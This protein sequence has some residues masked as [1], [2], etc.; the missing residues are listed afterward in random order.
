MKLRLSHQEI[1][2]TGLGIAGRPD[3]VQE[4]R[5]WLSMFLDRFY[6][7]Q[8]VE[9]LVKPSGDLALVEG[10]SLPEDYRAMKSAT[11]RQSNGSS[12]QPK[13]IWDAE[14]FSYVKRA[15]AS[16]APLNV[17]IDQNNRTLHFHPQPT[18]SYSIDIN[19]YHYPE[20]EAYN[21]DAFL[22][23]IPKWE[24]PSAI[25]VDFVTSAAALY[26]DDERQFNLMQLVEKSI[27]SSKM[28]SGDKRAGSSKLKLGKSFNK[29]F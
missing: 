21:S 14:E 15:Q 11:I 24:L 9:W 13:I 1:I 18:T 3:L 20:V 4:A 29:R 10:M 7:D 23:A 22:D 8:D 17:F 12:F 2:E 28:N 16:G 19:Y 6:H 27:V 26:N 5:L 25:L